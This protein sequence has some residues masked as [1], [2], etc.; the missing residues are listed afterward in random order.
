M[1]EGSCH[2]ITINSKRVIYIPFVSSLVA[3]L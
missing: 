3:L 1:S 2:E